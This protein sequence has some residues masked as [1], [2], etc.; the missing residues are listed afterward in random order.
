MYGRWLGDYPAPL[1]RGSGSPGW[2]LQGT[3]SRRRH[4]LWNN[5]WIT[6][7]PRILG[8]SDTVGKVY[9]SL[10]WVYE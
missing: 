6:L 5:E 8:D 10:L 3:F 9:V 4:G 1:S 7:H 2:C